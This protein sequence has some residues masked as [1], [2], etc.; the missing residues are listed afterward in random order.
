[1]SAVPVRESQTLEEINAK[2]RGDQPSPLLT[3]SDMELRGAIRSDLNRVQDFRAQEIR[4]QLERLGSVPTVQQEQAIGE[5]VGAIRTTDLMRKYSDA[6]RMSEAQGIYRPQT[7]AQLAELDR[8]DTAIEANPTSGFMF[9]GVGAMARNA[10]DVGLSLYAVTSTLARASSTVLPGSVGKSLED[11]AQWLDEGRDS[12]RELVMSGQMAP[13][14]GSEATFFQQLNYRGSKD[15]W[16]A[17]TGNVAF[18]AIPSAASALRGVQAAKAFNTVV[19]SLM[20]LQSAGQGIENY[21]RAEL[22]EGRTPNPWKAIGVGIGYAAAE[23]VTEKLDAIPGIRGLWQQLSSHGASKIATHLMRGDAGGATHYLLNSIGMANA[24]GLEEVITGE[25]QALIDSGLYGGGA[26][27]SWGDRVNEYA[28]GAAGGAMVT[29]GGSFSPVFREAMLSA[30]GPTSPGQVERK[31]IADFETF[32]DSPQ[33]RMSALAQAIASA[34]PDKTNSME[35]IRSAATKQAEAMG[36]PHLAEKIM[37]ELAKPVET[38]AKPV[39]ELVAE[40][41]A[42]VKAVVGT[43][44]AI[45]VVGESSV[46]GVRLIEIESADSLPFPAY[47]TSDGNTILV[48]RGAEDFGL[49]A[50]E[51]V[52]VF[53]QQHPEVYGELV[54]STAGPVL[55]YAATYA[56]D[57]AAAGSDISTLTPEQR[58]EEGAARMVELVAGKAGLKSRLSPTQVSVLRKLG[59]SFRRSATRAGLRGP[60]AKAV[61]RAFDAIEN[62]PTSTKEGPDKTTSM[63]VIDPRWKRTLG[64]RFGMFAVRRSNDDQ[65]ILPFGTDLAK[66]MEELRDVAIPQPQG[67]TVQATT[68]TEPRPTARPHL[69]AAMKIA[70]AGS[71]MGEAFKARTLSQA[72]VKLELASAMQAALP[73]KVGQKFANRILDASTEAE[74]RQLV[75]SAHAAYVNLTAADASRDAGAEAERVA[76]LLSSNVTNPIG[77]NVRSA[78]QSETQ[79]LREMVR[80]F[81]SASKAER[82]TLR[83]ALREQRKLVGGY[84][85]ARVS[86][87]R[88]ASKARTAELRSNFAADRAKAKERLAKAREEFAR[89]RTED[90]AGGRARLK[91]LRRTMLGRLAQLRSRFASDKAAFEK[92]Q[93]DAADLVKSALP[94]AIQGPILARLPRA[95]TMLQMQRLLDS[96][97]RSL[98]RYNRKVALKAAQKAVKRV[99]RRKLHPAEEA[100]FFYMAQSIGVITANVPTGKSPSQRR[101]KIGASAADLL[102]QLDIPTNDL[103]TVKAQADGILDRW[104]ARKDGLVSAWK[105]QVEGAAKQLGDELKAHTKALRKDKYGRPFR[106]IPALEVPLRFL[107]LGHMDSA[108]AA[109]FVFGDNSLGLTLLYRDLRNGYNAKLAAVHSDQDYI[110]DAIRRQN[111]DLGSDDLAMMSEGIARSHGRRLSKGFRRITPRI[112]VI[113]LPDGGTIEVTEAERIWLLGTILSQYNRS[114]I[115]AGAPVK[116]RRTGAVV[117]LSSDD[118]N[119]IVA[120]ATAEERAIYDAM[121]TWHNSTAQGRV[122]D[123]AIERLGYDI[124]VDDYW[125]SPR[126]QTEAESSAEEFGPKTFISLGMT[127]ERVGGKKPLMV[128][129]AFV[130]FL[131]HS[132]VTAGIA[133]QSRGIEFARASIDH[134]EFRKVNDE[135]GWF[136]YRQHFVNLLNDMDREWTGKGQDLGD[137]YFDRFLQRLRNRAVS[138]ILG[139]NPGVAL[140]QPLGVMSLT[141]VLSPMDVSRAMGSGAGI[142]LSLDAEIRES[143][144]LRQRMDASPISLAT[145]DAGG[146]PGIYGTRAQ[147][148]LPMVLISAADNFVV[149]VAWKAAKM[150]AERT[151]AG[152][153]P[154]AIRKET[155]RI[156]EEAIAA[157]QPTGDPLHQS[158]VGREARRNGA[159]SLLTM[160]SSQLS[161]NWNMLARSTMRASRAPTP[162]NL[163]KLTYDVAVVVAANSIGASLVRQLIQQAI[164]TVGGDDDDVKLQER[165]V[166]DMIAN[167]TGMIYGGAYL[168]FLADGIASGGSKTFGG[169]SVSP[170]ADTMTQ[171]FRGLIQIARSEGPKDEKFWQGMERSMVNFAALNGVPVSPYRLLRK[172]LSEDQEKRST[173]KRTPRQAAFGT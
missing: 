115:D 162:A 5:A 48:Q 166:R 15:T 120:S 52:H 75:L 143:P 31:L 168:S 28:G 111:V 145:G 39:D 71:M 30:P 159:L 172:A 109:E 24:E 158:A 63:E 85:N 152:A 98:E 92:M 122:R 107:A 64:E 68:F 73:G 53:R 117:H 173:T 154:E 141:V 165:L 101:R 14:G 133:H 66:A 119:A 56:Q 72:N 58:V 37:A 156:A 142:D 121:K 144:M 97:Q 89:V 130:E 100:Q 78:E 160:F 65:M 13:Y 3:M 128:E 6:F 150:K 16:G 62:P 163:S 1:M 123:R 67:G 41:V 42:D 114:M 50:H 129:D 29:L 88:Q 93:A 104:R 95:R 171:F 25:F 164:S 149:R 11:T 96:A 4:S 46:N 139:A 81:K 76:D 110:H 33:G 116:I 32:A 131:R 12:Y 127:Q 99:S 87:E 8:L 74:L 126:E 10:Q 140:M 47:A 138:G 38:P 108:T 57:L 153:T 146:T 26:D 51:L 80:Q 36:K 23:I 90:A 34:R 20:G 137:R 91:E 61:L 9:D 79:K 124:T 27:R 70:A 132:W 17:W 125:P 103:E 84:V 35:V 169:P 134:A 19:M 49:V 86:W 22:M 54:Q 21:R 155:A 106:G 59:D 151:L 112:H 18:Y 161:K 118:M 82:G 105:A 148:Q 157:T 45:T 94:T 7:D 147:G 77:E 102:R 69:A 44:V 60:V 170:V 135:R 83:A 43:D 2:L 113:D 136:D 55:A 167:A 40:Y